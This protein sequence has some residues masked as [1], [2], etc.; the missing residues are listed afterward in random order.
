M[1]GLPR[2]GLLLLLLACHIAFSRLIVAGWAL[3]LPLVGHCWIGHWF[4]D[5][6]EAMGWAWLPGCYA[7]SADIMP[8][9]AIAIVDGVGRYWLKAIATLAEGCHSHGVLHFDAW[10]RSSFPES[11]NG[12]GMPGPTNEVNAQ[13]ASL[14]S[15]AFIITGIP[16]LLSARASPFPLSPSSGRSFISI[17]FVGFRSITGFRCRL[18]RLPI[19]HTPRLIELFSVTGFVTTD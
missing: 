1:F 6:A 5:Y 8:L 9:Y 17:I 10:V 11:V 15:D 3:R 16:G 7:L 12:I 4:I 13:D 2:L 14:V 19:S 18:F